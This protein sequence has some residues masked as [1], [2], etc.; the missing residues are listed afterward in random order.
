MHLLFADPV[1]QLEEDFIAGLGLGVTEVE[2]AVTSDSARQLHVLLLNCKT[3]GVDGAQVNVLQE[4]YDLG[5]G[6]FLGCYKR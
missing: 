6:S 5:L 2:V 3:L 4:A 1:W